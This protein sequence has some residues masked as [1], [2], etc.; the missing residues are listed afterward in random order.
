MPRR[1]TASGETSPVHRRKELNL[2]Y[3]LPIGLRQKIADTLNEKRL[4]YKD[5]KD[6]IEISDVQMA[7][8]LH[9]QRPCYSD[10]LIGL[11]Y[12]IGDDPKMAT[13]PDFIRLDPLHKAFVPMLRLAGTI[14]DTLIYR[15]FDMTARKITRTFEK[16]DEISQARALFDLEK[17]MIDIFEKY[18]P[19]KFSPDNLPVIS[20]PRSRHLEF[21]L[22]EA[23]REFQEREKRQKEI[24]RPLTEYKSI[25]ENY[26]G[27]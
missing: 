15:E 24:L 25:L 5:I 10:F 1:R 9:A 19:C 17:S 13:L 8:I 7:R 18:F 26:R 2:Q 21:H 22:A 4:C 6:D 23:S 16:L 3:Y 27:K 14:R 11:Y 20:R 12:V